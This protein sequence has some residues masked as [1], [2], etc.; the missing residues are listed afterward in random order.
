[1]SEYKKLEKIMKAFASAIRLE[2]LTYIQQGIGSPNEI[3]NKINRP[4]ST[5]ENH[6]NVL[7]EADAVKKIPMKNKQGQLTVTYTIQKNAN[8]LLA[9]IKHLL[10]ENSD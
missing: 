3:A 8:I 2:I 10:K 6:L 7:V 1:M 4:R 5:I 9:N